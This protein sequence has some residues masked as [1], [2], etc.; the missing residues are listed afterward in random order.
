MALDPLKIVNNTMVA[1][2]VEEVPQESRQPPGRI[3]QM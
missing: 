3:A 2:E 1:P